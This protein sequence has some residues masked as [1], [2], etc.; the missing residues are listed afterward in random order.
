[1]SLNTPTQTEQPAV[2]KPITMPGVFGVTGQFTFTE[3]PGT[4][5]M[6]NV[7]YNLTLNDFANS[8]WLLVNL[9]DSGGVAFIVGPQ[10]NGWSNYLGTWTPTG[11]T[12]KV[13]FT[14][15][16]LGV[17]RLWVDGTEIALVFF[18][19]GAG[20]PAQPPNTAE[21]NVFNLDGPG[22]SKSAVVSE[23]FVASGVLPPTTIFCCP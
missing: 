22:P 20:G 15:D 14:V 3:F 18:A 4:A 10:P 23:V 16:A 17:P 7:S 8:D 13:H 21:F 6:L 11:G 1:M 5:G 9:D 2:S 12:H 19:F